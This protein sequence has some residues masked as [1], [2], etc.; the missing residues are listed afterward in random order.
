MAVESIGE[1]LTLSSQY[2]AFG[3]QTR[4]KLDHV[5]LA[6]HHLNDRMSPIPLVPTTLPTGPFTPADTDC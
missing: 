3:G 1:R 4:P 2:S 6:S 5:L